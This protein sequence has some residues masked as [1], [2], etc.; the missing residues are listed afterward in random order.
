LKVEQLEPDW[1][2]ELLGVI[3]SPTIAYMLLLIGVYGLFFE[4]YTPAPYSPV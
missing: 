4:G 1:K 3:T 2:S